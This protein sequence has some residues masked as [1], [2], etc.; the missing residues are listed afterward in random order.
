MDNY[1]VLDRLRQCKPWYG[2]EFM[3][4][5]IPEVLWPASV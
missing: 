4:R 5:N 2:E 3:E 1:S